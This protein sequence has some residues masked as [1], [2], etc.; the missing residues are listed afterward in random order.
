MNYYR[1]DT[2]VGVFAPDGKIPKIL[3]DHLSGRIRFIPIPADRWTHTDFYV[4]SAGLTIAN[5]RAAAR[6]KATIVVLP[7]AAMWFDQALINFAV[8]PRVYYAQKQGDT[9]QLPPPTLM[10]AAQ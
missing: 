4:T 5:E 8:Q 6:L 7:E 1:G 9:P 2:T 3:K 10:E